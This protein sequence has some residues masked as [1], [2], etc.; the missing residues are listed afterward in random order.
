MSMSVMYPTVDYHTL[1]DDVNLQFGTDIDDLDILLFGYDS[2]N[3][4][5]KSFY[6]GEMEIFEGHPWQN[7]EDIRLRNLVRAYLKDVLPD[8]DCVLINVSW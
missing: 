2:S 4:S 7:E 3:N 5:F 6:Y 8:Y 1:Q